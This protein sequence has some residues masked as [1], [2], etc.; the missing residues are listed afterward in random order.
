MFLTSERILVL[1]GKDCSLDRSDVVSL[2]EL[3]RGKFSCV[4]T[5]GDTWEF[6]HAKGVVRANSNKTNTDRFYLSLK[7]AL[8]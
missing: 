7:D 8:S 2:S 6:V 3:N 4:A 1:W 5:N